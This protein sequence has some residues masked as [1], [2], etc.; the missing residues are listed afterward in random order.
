MHLFLPLKY[1]V[2]SFFSFNT[3]ECFENSD[4]NDRPVRSPEVRKMQTQ[5]VKSIYSFIDVEIL[6]SVRRL[7]AADTKRLYVGK[8]DEQIPIN[9]QIKSIQPFKCLQENEYSVH[10]IKGGIQVTPYF[11]YNW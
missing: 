11:T 4:E 10:P 9:E 5:L 7:L 6:H 1:C 3:L 8:R 2:S